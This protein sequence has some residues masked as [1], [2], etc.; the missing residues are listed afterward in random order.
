MT[1]TIAWYDQHTQQPIPQSD[2]LNAHDAYAVARCDLDG[3]AVT[4][5]SR[6]SGQTAYCA[7]GHRWLY[8]GGSVEEP[9][10]WRQVP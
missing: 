4:L 6:T 9:G 5:P 10:A 7:H 2:D 8:V 3:S 1:F